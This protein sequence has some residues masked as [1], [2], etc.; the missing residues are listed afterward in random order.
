MNSTPLKVVPYETSLTPL[1]EGCGPASPLL[2]ILIP[3]YNEQHTIATLLKRVMGVRYHKEIVV[4]DDGSSDG[5]LQALEEFKDFANIIVLNH[6]KNR[7][8]G[9][10]VRTALERAN[11][12]FCIIQDADLEYDPS[13]IVTVLQPLLNNESD[14]VYG[15]RYLSGDSGREF[16]WFRH[17][18]SL[19]NLVILLLYG[20][21]LTDSATCYK[22][23]STRL[24]R[25]LKLRSCRFEFC[26]EVTAKLSLTG[27][28][29]LEVPISY[30][31][32]S[33]AT[34]KKIRWHDGLWAIST[35]LK[36]RICGFVR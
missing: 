32:R 15:S 14:V 9:A 30:N 6:A 5:T 36:W 25:S 10:A 33:T 23:M 17:G 20:I 18:V 2:S 22:A 11:G 7:G 27:V 12:K 13:D 21:R 28:S 8:K 29:I 4:V 31:P 26:P 34:G 1:S 35:L 16:R 24:L 3:V 19:L